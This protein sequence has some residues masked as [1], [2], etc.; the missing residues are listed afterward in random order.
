MRHYDKNRVKLAMYKLYNSLK[1]WILNI[2]ID[3]NAWRSLFSAPCS[4]LYTCMFDALFTGK[5]LF[6]S[7]TF[8]QTMQLQTFFIAVFLNYW[9]SWN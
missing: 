8:V 5:G 3:I 6:H 2:D 1:K 9:I 4:F 7:F